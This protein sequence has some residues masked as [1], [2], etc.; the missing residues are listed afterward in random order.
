[1]ASVSSGVWPVSWE[2]ASVPA[3][4]GEA[5]LLAPSDW[6]DLAGFLGHW[7]FNSVARSGLGRYIISS[8]SITFVTKASRPR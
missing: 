2:R 8:H 5:A 3:Q 7:M 1:M 4:E 6:S